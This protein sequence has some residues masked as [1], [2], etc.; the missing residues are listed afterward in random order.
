MSIMVMVWIGNLLLERMKKNRL[1]PIN[2]RIYNSNTQSK[3][4]IILENLKLLACNGCVNK[5]LM[6]ILLIKD[7]I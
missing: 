3:N 6:L 4:D 5:A 7:M 2:F 1:V